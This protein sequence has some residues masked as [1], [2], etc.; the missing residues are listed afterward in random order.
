M[1]QLIVFSLLLLIWVYSQFSIGKRNKKNL[2]RFQESGQKLASQM[3]ALRT[4]ELKVL[5]NSIDSLESK[6]KKDHVPN[7][8]TQN[9]FE[10]AESI[11]YTKQR[12]KTY[13]DVANQTFYNSSGSLVFLATTSANEELTKS[14]FEALLDNRSTE[15]SNEVI[16]L[17]KNRTTA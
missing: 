1:I 7:Q 11:V 10:V 5:A 15:D 14:D 3:E 13:Y 2:S 16:E 9:L 8:D 12:I 17:Y 6:Q 4:E